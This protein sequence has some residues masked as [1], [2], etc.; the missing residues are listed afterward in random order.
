MYQNIHIL[1]VCPIHAKDKYAPPVCGTPQCS[2]AL[3]FNLVRRPSWLPADEHDP[4]G[5]HHHH[6]HHH[7]HNW[8][9][10]DHGSL[11]GLAMVKIIKANNACQAPCY[12]HKLDC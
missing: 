7:H 9:S 2:T 4:T 11:V 1:I 6:H 5:C 10:Q 3:G 8:P 12:G